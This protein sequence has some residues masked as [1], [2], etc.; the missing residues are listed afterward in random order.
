MGSNSK[1][2]V[3]DPI[4]CNATGGCQK[5]PR[6]EYIVDNQCDCVE[7]RR[8]SG[9]QRFTLTLD[10]FIQHLTEGRIAFVR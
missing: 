4:D 2:V 3:K 1:A 7:L 8:R 6:G 10:A 5:A 9:E